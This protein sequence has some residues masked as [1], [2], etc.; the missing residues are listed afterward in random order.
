M[1]CRPSS[2]TRLPDLPIISARDRRG[3]IGS[4]FKSGTHAINGLA[5]DARRWI[6]AVET[7]TDRRDLRL[8]TLTP[9]KQVFC[10]QSLFRNTQAWCPE[11]FQE[12]RRTGEPIYLPLSWHLRMVTICLKHRQPLDTVCPHCGEGFGPLFA[13]SR[14]GCCSRCWRWLAE[15]APRR[16]EVYRGPDD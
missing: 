1:L 13:K 16:A 6:I 12:W 10:K 14:P 5:E 9:L 2:A 15:A 8:L 4:G 3:R 11:C 7:A